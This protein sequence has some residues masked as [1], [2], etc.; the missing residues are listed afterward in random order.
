M[1]LGDG[2]LRLANVF[3]LHAP[4]VFANLSVR[5]DEDHDLGSSEEDVYMGG[6]PFSLRV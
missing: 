3:D 5:A 6:C 1:M 4:S 2:M